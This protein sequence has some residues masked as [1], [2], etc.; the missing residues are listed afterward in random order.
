MTGATRRYH[1]RIA[2][3]FDFDLT[4]APD[5][6]N[7]LLERCGVEPERWR[8]EHIRPLAESGWD[9]SLAHFYSLI[10]L[11]RSG[12]GPRITRALL[13]E[14]GRGSEPFPGVPAMFGRLRAR[15]RAILPELEVEFHLLSCGFVELQ[16]ATRFASEFTGMWGSEFHFDDHGEIAFARQ[17]I[18]HPEK[19]HYVLALSKGIGMRGPNE[20]ADAWRPLA[21]DELHVPL[22]QI[23][24]VGDGASDM[25]TF[26]LLNE[27][28]GIAL[29]V[30]KSERAQ[31]WGGHAEMRPER[32]VENLAPA[33]FRDGAE[34]MTSLTLGLESIAKRIALRRLGRGE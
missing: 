27:H 12:R 15:A 6:M 4:L 29:A 19:V 16:R 34:L 11:S 9:A 31:D 13:E 32:R 5:S 18:T 14:V 17:V 8:N 3:I 23:I 30:F 25:P 28:G 7:A 21:D 20:P 1:N 26:A 22:D 10:E 33:D 2:V 24:Y